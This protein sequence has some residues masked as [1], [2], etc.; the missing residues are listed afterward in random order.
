MLGKST[1]RSES[2]PS[3]SSSLVGSSSEWTP[4][5]PISTGMRMRWRRATLLPG[6]FRRPRVR[7][8]KWRLLLLL[9]SLGTGGSTTPPFPRRRMRSPT[10]ALHRTHNRHGARWRGGRGGGAA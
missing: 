10:S 5:S 7:M 2:P 8:L 6:G 9:P 4:T 3:S 1:R